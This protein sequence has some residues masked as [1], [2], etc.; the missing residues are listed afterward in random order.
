MILILTHIAA[1]ILG[2]VS[3][4]LHRL[5]NWQL[6]AEEIL[7]EHGYTSDEAAELAGSETMNSFRKAGLSPTEAIAR[8]MA[9]SEEYEL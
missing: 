3:F 8:A 6:D 7:I 5:V 2:V 9:S 1:F 4:Y